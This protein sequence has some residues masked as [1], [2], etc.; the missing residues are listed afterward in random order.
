MAKRSILITGS[1]GFIGSHLVEELDGPFRVVPYDIKEDPKFDILNMNNLYDAMEY[2]DIVIHCAAT[3]G[4]DSVDRRPADVMITNVLG[5]YNILNRASMLNNVELVINFSTSEVYGP[6]V[7]DGRESDPTLQEAI[8]DGRWHYAVSKLAGEYMA[9]CFYRQERVNYVN[10]RPFNIFGPA[11]VGDGAIHNMVI[12]ALEGEDVIVDNSGS[13]IRSWCYI[14]DFV[15]AIK[16]ILAYTEKWNTTYN[17]GNPK[18]TRTIY[19][20][21]EKI[22][23]L[24]GSKAGIICKT[25]TGPEVQYRMPNI[26]KLTG[27]VGFTP[28]IGLEEGLKRTIEW[29]RSKL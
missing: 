29:Y 17:I 6:R 20:L 5:T 15:T 23:A 11:Q 4:I 19:A 13:Q 12:K 25:R 18:N 10:V 14:D 24:T 7:Y 2:T 1:S 22:I 16:L 26:E 8:G 27:A 21:A 3:C 28:Q 9:D